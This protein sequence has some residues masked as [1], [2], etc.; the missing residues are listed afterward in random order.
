MFHAS[1]TYVATIQELML[2]SGHKTF[3]IQSIQDSARLFLPL[4]ILKRK[5]RPLKL[6]NHNR[7]HI[8]GIP[9]TF[10]TQAICVT[11]YATVLA[12]IVMVFMIKSRRI[13]RGVQ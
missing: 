1:L 2:Y 8:H 10:T 12:I 9:I 7:R 11:T 3:L 5:P 4:A 6:C 13:V